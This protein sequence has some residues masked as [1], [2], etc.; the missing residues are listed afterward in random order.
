MKRTF[1]ICFMMF[2]VIYGHTQSKK[3]K[4][5][6]QQTEDFCNDISY[7]NKE[8]YTRYSNLIT[9]L[10][11]GKKVLFISSIPKT[12]VLEGEY[13]IYIYENNLC[14]AT[15]DIVD[16]D[17]VYDHKKSCFRKVPNILNQVRSILFIEYLRN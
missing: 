15:Y 13:T 14:T 12:G 2:L 10:E 8:G 16:Y 11:K 9:D 6:L 17:Y 5:E 3:I 7:I 4:I 1:A